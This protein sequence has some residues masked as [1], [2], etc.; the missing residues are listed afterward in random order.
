MKIKGFIVSVSDVIPARTKN[1]QPKEACLMVN[2]K[3]SHEVTS[4]VLMAYYGESD[5]GGVEG[6][7][8]IRENILKVTESIL[9]P[10]VI[11]GDYGQRGFE[12]DSFAKAA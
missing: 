8:L 1:G 4:R 2:F 10:V 3:T 11:D 6:L 12:V 7:K 9:N 5:N